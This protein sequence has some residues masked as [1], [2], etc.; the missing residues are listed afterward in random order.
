MLDQGG[1]LALKKFIANDVE[2]SEFGKY[3]RCRWLGL[4]DIL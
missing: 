2:L 4:I 3:M 1:E